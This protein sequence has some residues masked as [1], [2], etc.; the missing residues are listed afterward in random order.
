[1]EKKHKVYFDK[2]H[3]GVWWVDE[4]VDY[5]YFKAIN[6]MTNEEKEYILSWTRS[7]DIKEDKNV[8]RIYDVEIGIGE[9][10]KKYYF[11]FYYESNRYRVVARDPMELEKLLRETDITFVGDTKPDEN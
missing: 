3:Y 5:Y 9:D 4:T 7:I 2:E 8:V 1:M 6:I 11:N 10:A